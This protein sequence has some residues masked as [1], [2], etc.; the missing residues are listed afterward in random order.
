MIP[1]EKTREFL[2]HTL[3][4]N[5]SQ[6]ESF[7]Y[8]SDQSYP[9][10]EEGFIYSGSRG[11]WVVFLDLQKTECHIGYTRPT[12]GKQNLILLN[13]V[14]PSPFLGPLRTSYLNSLFLPK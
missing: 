13:S 8:E 2:V 10:Q 14:V 3:R 4:D 6:F 1:I 12:R 9:V 7:N 11:W 5:V